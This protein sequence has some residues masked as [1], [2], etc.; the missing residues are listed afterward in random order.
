MMDR[1]EQK[2]QMCTGKQ[3]GKL[4]DGKRK[5][6]AAGEQSK[7]QKQEQWSI[8]Y[9]KDHCFDDARRM[10]SGCCSTSCT[11]SGAPPSLPLLRVRAWTASVAS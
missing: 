3:A 10:S 8:S 2:E 4:S 9:A 5:I 7:S 6:G 11:A 1:K